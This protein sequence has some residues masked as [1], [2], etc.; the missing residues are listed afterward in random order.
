MKGGL[1][2]FGAGVDASVGLDLQSAMADG[3]EEEYVSSFQVVD[4]ATLMAALK[5]REAACAPFLKPM[6]GEPLKALR[7]SLQNPPYATNTESVKVASCELVCRALLL[8]K[9]AEIESALASLSLDDCDVLMK[10][11][12]RALA[13]PG[14]KQE[15]YTA[16]L[17]WHPAVLKRAGPASI[18][19]TFAEVERPL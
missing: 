3:E 8:I 7:I 13:L 17:K 18:V 6:G 15:H 9:E 5:E 4:D 10:Y 14:K 11:L 16:M 1:S 12:Y 19:R 2:A